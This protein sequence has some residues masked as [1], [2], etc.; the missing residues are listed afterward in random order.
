M[1]GLGVSGPQVVEGWYGQTFAKPL[2]RT[3]E[4]V[5]IV[6]EVVARKAPV[7]NDGPELPAALPGRDRARQ[8]AQVDR[9]SPALRDPDNPR[10]R[11]S[12]ERRSRGRDRRRVVPDLLLAAPHGRIHLRIGRRLRVAAAPGVPGTTS[13][14]SLCARSS[15]HDDAESAADFMRPMLALYIGGMGARDMNFHFDV[16]CRMGFEADAQEDPGPLPRRTQRRGRSRR[17]LRPW[18]RRSLSSGPAR[19]S[20]KSSSLEGLDRHDPFSRREPR[21]SEDDGR[22][23]SIGSLF[24]RQFVP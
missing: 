4:Y 16:F 14:S 6:R 11:R 13:R 7:T 24:S 20:Q 10:S 9:P 15:S 5:S 3:R 22:V 23:R 12:E 1:L 8:A 17:S 19:R 18:S 21:S 2:A